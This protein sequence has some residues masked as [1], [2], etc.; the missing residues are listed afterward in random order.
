AEALPRGLYILLLVKEA[1]IGLCLAFVI[2][3]MFDT[4]DA[5]GGM[6]DLA[7]GATLGNVFNPLTQAQS[8]VSSVFFVQLGV[9]LFLTVGGLQAV[10][11]G[12]GHSF[13][14]APLYAVAP[15]ELFGPTSGTVGTTIGLVSQLMVV[16]LRL[17][18]P[19]IV[20]LLLIDVV[21]GLINKVAPQ[22]QVFFIG[23][24]I[25]ATVG[26]AVL[27]VGMAVTFGVVFEHFDAFVISM[28]GLVETGGG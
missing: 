14:A 12:L 20:V 23:L 3:L 9:V 1:A 21:L 27:L 8:P 16:A 2:T 26:V 22:I 24:S 10:L 15:P 4:L 18:A 11:D 25:K 28:R 6:V 19:V 17:A 13:T 7:R 5:F